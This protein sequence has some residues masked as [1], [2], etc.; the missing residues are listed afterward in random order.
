[1]APIGNHT[2][3]NIVSD[4]WIT[5]GRIA[6]MVVQEMNPQAVKF[7]HRGAV[8]RGRRWFGDA[9][10]MQLSIDKLR[11]IG[12][13]PKCS[14]EEAARLSIKDARSGSPAS[15]CQNSTTLQG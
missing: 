12:C 7:S 14:S 1:V 10:F 4:N 2:F 3:K 11:E 5:A 8:D 9:K 6:E 15:A 13:N